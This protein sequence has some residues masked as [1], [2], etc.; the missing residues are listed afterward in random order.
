[1]TLY[2]LSTALLIVLVIA[3]LGVL[4]WPWAVSA[5]VLGVLLGIYRVRRAS[6]PVESDQWQPNPRKRESAE[7]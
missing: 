6:R 4:P 2:L 7:S 5:L 3:S 1:V